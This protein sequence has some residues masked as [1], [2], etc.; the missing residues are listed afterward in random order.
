M[1]IKKKVDGDTMVFMAF[2]WDEGAGVDV[3]GNW[4]NM[5]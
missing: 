1:E 4:L 2:I 3:V 5:R